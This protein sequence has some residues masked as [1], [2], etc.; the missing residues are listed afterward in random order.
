MENLTISNEL[1]CHDL[2]IESTE[3]VQVLMFDGGMSLIH[4]N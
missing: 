2:D 3:V 1:K 4:L